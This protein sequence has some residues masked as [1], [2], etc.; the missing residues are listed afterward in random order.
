MIWRFAVAGIAAAFAAEPAWGTVAPADL[1]E[2]PNFA[3]LAISPDGETVAFRV[4]RARIDLNA[5]VSDWYVAHLA[6]GMVRRIGNGG[7]PIHVDPGISLPERPVWSPDGSTLFYRSLVDGAIAIWQAKS[8]GRGA[9]QVVRDAADILAFD[10]T[11]EGDALVYSV[12]ASRAE[13]ERSE[14][15]EYDLGIRLDESVDLAQAAFR[16]AVINGRLATQRLVGRWFARDALLWRRPV[17]I[18]RLELAT[19]I[20]RA[21]EEWADPS[22]SGGPE[23]IGGDNTAYSAV[24]GKATVHQADGIW[25]IEVQSP[26]K[27]VRSTHCAAIQCRERIDWLAWRPG[28]SELLFATRDRHQRQSLHLWNITGGKVR[29]IVRSDGLLSG[30]RDPWT[31]CAVADRFAVCVASGAISPPRLEAVDLATGDRVILH[32]PNQLIGKRLA[33]RAEQLSWTA[34]KGHEFTGILL[35]PSEPP[36]GPLPLFITYYACDGFLRGG[37][38]DE[39][40]LATFAAKGIAALCINRTS[41]GNLGSAEKD[42]DAALLGIEKIVDQLAIEGR[43]DRA[44]VG[45]GG[46]SFGASVALWTAFKSELLQ[47][48][49]LASPSLEPS[50]YW[51]NG[52]KGRDT[53]ERL[54]R[55]WGLGDPAEAATA[56]KNMSPALNVDQIEAAV[57]MQLPEQEARLATEF[58]G[59]LSRSAIPSDFYI[60]PDEAHVKTQPRHKLAVYQRNLDWF[61]YWLQA[62][63]D[64]DPLKSEQYGLWDKMA[65]AADSSVAQ[66][67]SQSSNEAMPSKR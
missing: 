6:T 43:I 3:G 35:L 56:W 64:P 55:W 13:I 59:R 37:V 26:A 67:R 33:V 49:S 51:I 11:P 19:G 54:R 18:K 41:T 12:Q 39:W 9:R 32:D 24:A 46:L 14:K 40:P 25:S 21:A 22:L 50:Y 17:D 47:A 61:R 31:P 1:V 66:E 45:M 65:H 23:K 10:I 30:S 2:M 7:T 57:L 38:G 16:G 20:S 42:Y 4:E 44:H 53:H 36:T 29:T 60:F 27:L 28:K 48:V 63:R 62:Y 5:Y 8:D 52:F 34:G 58:I 15:A